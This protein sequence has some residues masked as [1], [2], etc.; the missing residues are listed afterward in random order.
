MKKIVI[1]SGTCGEG[2]KR[3]QQNVAKMLQQCCS[4]VVEICK[5]D[6]RA[7]ALQQMW[8]ESTQ[9]QN[10]RPTLATLPEKKQKN[11]ERRKTIGN[12]T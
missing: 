12:A 9:L 3:K 8:K 6:G 5:S 7:S 10:Q 11:H 1:V 2:K 4:N